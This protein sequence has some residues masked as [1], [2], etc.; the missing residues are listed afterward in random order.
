MPDQ[1]THT[2]INVGDVVT[3]DQIRALPLDAVVTD[4]D[5]DTYRRIASNSWTRR[6]SDEPNGYPTPWTT[7]QVEQLTNSEGGF[8]PV[9][10][11]SLPNGASSM[12]TPDLFQQAR[13][14]LRD[15]FGTEPTAQ[16]I[17]AVMDAHN[18][19][20]TTIHETARR[21]MT[22]KPEAR[23]Q[24]YQL[25]HDLTVTITTG[26]VVASVTLDAGMYPG[27]ARKTLHSVIDRIA[28]QIGA[29]R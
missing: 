10:L 7:R 27:T 24:T 29:L 15:E 1:N 14:A 5:G 16:A 12:G 4:S 3:A 17:G 20:L 8:P 25:T 23:E 18:P 2:V 22:P 9:L 26:D 19:D 21:V 28:D 11:T 13:I 6:S